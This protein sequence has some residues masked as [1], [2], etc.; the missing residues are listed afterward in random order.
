[1]VCQTR[2][3]TVSC[4]GQEDSAS[5]ARRRS[6]PQ[7]RVRVGRT[8]CRKH[9][10]TIPR[11]CGP[12]QRRR[13]WDAV[14]AAQGAAGWAGA[15]MPQ[16]R[17]QA[18]V[19]AEAEFRK[20]QFV[21][22]VRLGGGRVSRCPR[23]RP[24]RHD[25]WVWWRWRADK[26]PQVLGTPTFVAGPFII[27]V[28]EAPV[29]PRPWPRLF[30]AHWSASL[31]RSSRPAHSRSSSR[32]MTAR[33]PD[34]LSPSRFPPPATFPAASS[35]SSPALAEMAP[36]LRPTRDAD[37]AIDLPRRRYG[38]GLGDLE[39]PVPTPNAPTGDGSRAT[40]PRLWIT[41]SGLGLAAQSHFD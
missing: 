34:H 16:P 14:V 10:R 21:E 9:P 4:R 7:R 20:A 8:P 17:R 25:R 5:S 29:S 15:T 30:P 37:N 28:P 36:W 27:S 40:E 13:K 19:H 38:P 31:R 1:M 41:G 2:R 32:A 24:G 26:Y 39:L 12:H 18:G 35:T 22:E 11:Q 3:S 6:S 33:S 23:H